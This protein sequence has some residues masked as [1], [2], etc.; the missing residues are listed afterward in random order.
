MPQSVYKSAQM[1]PSLSNMK[2]CSLMGFNTDQS[3]SVLLTV[4]T[5]SRT[6]GMPLQFQYFTPSFLNSQRFGIVISELLKS[7]R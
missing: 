1:A 5:P 3:C 2:Y 7:A 4:S 6:V